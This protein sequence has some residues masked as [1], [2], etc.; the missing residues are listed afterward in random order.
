[1]F[2][3]QNHNV[4]NSERIS[5]PVVLEKSEI[6]RSRTRNV[7]PQ[8]A[9]R[10]TGLNRWIVALLAVSAVAWTST[11]SA[12]TVLDFDTEDDFVTPLI[13]GQS[14]DPAFD[15][16]DLEFGNLVNIS[17]RQLVPNGSGETHLGVAIFDSDPNGPNDNGPDGDL[18]VDTGNILILQNDS[19]SATSNV[20]GFGLTYD[21]PNDESSEVD[22]G[23]IVFDFVKPVELISID[24][25]DAN[26]NF[27][28][29]LTLTDTNKR[30][31]VYTVNETYSFDIEAT[32]TGQGYD[33]VFL[34]TLLA[35]T[36][37]GGGTATVA[38]VSGFDPLSVIRFDVAI[39]GYG[40]D[41][42]SP[43]GAIDTLVFDSHLAPLPTS[44][45]MGMS[46]MGAMGMGGFVRR[47]RLQTV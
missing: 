5:N 28:A 42:S 13:N 26:G 47:R 15:G 22:A 9:T 41:G 10:G 31:R 7:P 30:R 29:T 23:A 14:I 32:P 34:N 18:L 43:S 8:I 16:A 20:A 19:N 17:S 24:V 36:G 45:W 35:Q 1:M 40:G 12:V 2:E 39:T 4:P 27:G 11:A 3:V 6:N 33:T 46:M 37:E 44:V 25:V 38:E 21:I